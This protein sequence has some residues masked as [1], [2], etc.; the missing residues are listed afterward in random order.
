[1]VTRKLINYFI[2]LVHLRKEVDILKGD[3]FIM[4]IVNETQLT[5]FRRGKDHSFKQSTW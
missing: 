1:M 3:Y 2:Y 4:T 5:P